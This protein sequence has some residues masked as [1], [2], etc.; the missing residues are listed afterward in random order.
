MKNNSKYWIVTDLD[1]TL[2]D[3]DYDIGPAKNTLKILAELNIPV[4]PC[5]SKTAA[6]VR[7]FR[8]QIGL[9]DPFIVEN[10]G[11]IYGDEDYSNNEWE[12]PLGESY[13]EF[14]FSVIFNCWYF[15]FDWILCHR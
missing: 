9:T 4:I 2:M 7:T 12:L 3:D 1:G 6:E 11:A 14:K 10:G 5:T 8:E 15:V 13:E